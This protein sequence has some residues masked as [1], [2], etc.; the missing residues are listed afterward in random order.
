[1]WLADLSP[2]RGRE[3]SGRRPVVLISTDSLNQGKSGLVV[4]CPITTRDRRIRTHIRVS[5]PEGGL[6]KTSFI[7]TEAV[8]SISKDRLH[9]YL[10]I[11]SQRTVLQAEDVLRI[12]L[13]L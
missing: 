13:E 5:P 2:T 11:V 12:L 3:Q 10:G 8:R 4:V 6:T 1:M 9:S 7:L